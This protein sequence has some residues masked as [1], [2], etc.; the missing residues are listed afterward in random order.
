MLIIIPDTHCNI[1]RFLN[2]TK[3]NEMPNVNVVRCVVGL[4]VCVLL[5]AN[6]VIHIS[7]ELVWDYGEHYFPNKKNLER[8]KKE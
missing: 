5:F 2:G 8:K 4:E 6:K 3:G 7:T 1:A